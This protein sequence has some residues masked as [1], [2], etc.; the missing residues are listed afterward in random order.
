MRKGHK[1]KLKF[2]VTLMTLEML[3]S[4]IEPMATILD[5]VYRLFPPLKNVLLHNTGGG[6]GIGSPILQM[7]RLGPGGGEG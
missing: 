5:N 1:L 6:L 7:G 2:S 4:H 3:N